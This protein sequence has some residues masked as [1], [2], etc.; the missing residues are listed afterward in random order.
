MDNVV[1]LD[2]DDPRCVEAMI[3]FMYN[4]EY[5]VFEN[6]LDYEICEGGQGERSEGSAMLFDVQMYQMA[7]KY[8]IAS[9]KGVCKKGYHRWATKHWTLLLFSRSITEIY[10]T[11]PREDRGLRDIVT[12]ISSAHE[13]ELSKRVDF[14]EAIQA[15]PE[16]AVDFIKSTAHRR[17][18]IDKALESSKR[19]D[20]CN[21]CCCN[22]YYR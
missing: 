16:F 8:E 18:D 22:R 6:D 12:D 17:T 13:S 5:E 3:S 11:T 14:L 7:D 2:N 1:R 20:H 10:S 15:T 19:R 21:G 4:L 9:L